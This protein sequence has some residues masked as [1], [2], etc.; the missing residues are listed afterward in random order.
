LSRRICERYCKASIY[1]TDGFHHPAARCEV[2][3]LFLEGRVR[4]A[5]HAK[6]HTFN[7]PRSSGKSRRS[8]RPAPGSNSSVSTPLGTTIT[9]TPGAR[10]GRSEASWPDTATFTA[11]PP[12]QRTSNFAIRLA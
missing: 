6:A 10:S 9:R 5:N 8:P 11:P 12:H 1:P 7:L 4:D 3:R 2:E